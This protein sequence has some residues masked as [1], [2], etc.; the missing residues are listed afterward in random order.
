MFKELYLF[1]PTEGLK[2]ALVLALSFILGLERE[3]KK[4]LG[5]H[6]YFGGVRVFPLIGLFG[7]GV[8]LL[9]GPNL[10]PLAIGLGV[11]GAFFVVSYWHKIS[12][13]TEAGI[14]NEISGLITFVLGALIHHEYY[15]VAATLVV[16]SLL[17]L[18]L[19]KVLESLTTRISPDEIVTF[20]KFLLLTAVILPVI[21]NQAFGPFQLNPYKIWMVVVAVSTISY[22]SYVLQR[23]TKSRDSVPLSALFG[24]TYSSTI[25]TVVLAK[26]AREQSRPHLFSGSILM[27]SGMMYLRLILLLAIFSQD[28]MKAVLVPFSALAA[29]GCLAGWLWS[30]RPDPSIPPEKKENEI[31]NPLE[32]KSAFLFAGIFLAVLVLTHLTITYLG[33]RGMYTFAALM[34]MTDVDPFILGLTQS[35]GA[36]IA[37]KSAFTA[38][39]IATS[40]NN[41]IKGIYAFVFADRQTGRQSLLALLLL[42]IAGLLPLFWI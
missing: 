42:A 13:A 3:E 11:M 26:R 15:W 16:I 12:T 1:L 23:L 41:A 31:K 21:P 36:T 32:L 34:G 4:V 17:L 33:I 35:A 38:I 39:L 28:L 27:A 30:L 22:A 25:T 7:Y 5:E 2:I 9:S 14:S 24:G 18:E 8:A 37:L 6:Y 40:S 10:L 29:T 20:T 19:K